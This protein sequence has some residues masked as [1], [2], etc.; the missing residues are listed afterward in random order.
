MIFEP[1]EN[2]HRYAFLPFCTYNNWM[3]LEL[4]AIVTHNKLDSLTY[5]CLKHNETG[6]S[7]HGGEQPVHCDG[8]I[9]IKN[10]T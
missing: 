5:K 4:L 8:K 10:N 6:E 7:F 9:S 2:G 1:Y 3:T